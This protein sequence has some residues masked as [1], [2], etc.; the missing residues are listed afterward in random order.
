MKEQTLT[1]TKHRL[2]VSCALLIACCGM[3]DAHATLIAGYDFLGANPL[4]DKVGS[5]DLTQRGTVAF[6]TEGSFS[7]ATFTAAGNLVYNTAST[8]SA[9]P[10]TIS[11]WIRGTQQSLGDAWAVN[12]NGDFDVEL[13]GSNRTDSASNNNKVSFGDLTDNTWNL[14]TI[15]VESTS[16]IN[17]WLN[18]DAVASTSAASLSG[19]LNDFM[20]GT[21]RFDFPNVTGTFTGNIGGVRIFSGDFTEAEHDALFAAGGPIAIPEPS[22]FALMGLAGLAAMFFRRRR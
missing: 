17:I 20:L 1:V 6:G 19:N 12:G 15:E 18:D 21:G 4:E 8:F 7:F 3:L 13:D 16:Q 22:A 2:G 9:A 10:Y 5:F 14:L 11:T